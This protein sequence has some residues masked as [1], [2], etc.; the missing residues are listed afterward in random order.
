MSWKSQRCSSKNKLINNIVVDVLS[1]R[2][3]AHSLH[4]WGGLFFSEGRG[5]NAA[6]WDCELSFC[7]ECK[8][9]K[10]QP[11]LHTEL[12]GL[13]CCRRKQLC[14]LL[15]CPHARLLTAA[16]LCKLSSKPRSPSLLHF[17]PERSQSRQTVLALPVLHGVPWSLAG[18]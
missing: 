17:S 2:K 1:V 15:Q 12:P 5:K 3:Y 9:K 8:G 14:P 7:V 13:S 16:C 6:D 18:F 4:N 11:S 10:K